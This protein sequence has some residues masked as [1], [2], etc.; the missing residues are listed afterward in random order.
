MNTPE[1]SLGL[2][3]FEEEVEQLSARYKAVQI[4]LQDLYRKLGDKKDDNAMYA[5]IISN[6]SQSLGFVDLFEKGEIQP[7]EIQT[8]LA[9][10][11]RSL[12]SLEKYVGLLLDNPGFLERESRVMSLG[13]RSSVRY[14]ENL[15]I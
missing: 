4:R 12:L 7:E 10:T 14:I 8:V 11:K 1:V 3:S 13:N 9:T 6:A 15:K 5:H 2:L